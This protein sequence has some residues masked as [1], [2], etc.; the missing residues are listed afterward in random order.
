MTQVRPPSRRRLLESAGAVPLLFPF[1]RR[2]RAAEAP[3]REPRL[4]LFMQTNGTST[5]QFFPDATFK[6]SAILDPL[7]S[8]QA[9]RTR[10]TVIHGLHNR[11]GGAGNGHDV[12]FPGLFSGYRSIGSFNEPWGGGPSLDQQLK[13]QLPLT[14]VFPTLNCGVLATSAPV[15]KQH[16]AS[17]SY[18]AARQPVPT[19][20]NVYKLYAMFFPTSTSGGSS[21]DSVMAAKRRLLQKRTV[22]DFVAGD[23][24]GLRARVGALDRAKLDVHEGALRE[25][26]K[27]LGATVAEGAPAQCRSARV[28]AS[29]LDLAV[30]DNIPQLARLMSDFVALAL[31]CGQTRMVTYAMGNGGERWWYRWLGLNENAHEDIAHRDFGDNQAI[32][33]KV[34]KIGR[35]HAEQVA[36]LARALDAFPEG[37]GSVLD[38][39]LLVWGNE[40]ATGTHA[41]ENIP[42]VTIGG[43][44]GRL[45]TI[46]RLVADGAQPY[47]RLG[48]TLLNLMG[49]RTAG[50]GEEP[51]CGNLSGVDIA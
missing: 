1:L 37:D 35:W 19:E 30:E 13:R 8:D 2:A 28:P 5:K 25:F 16:R 51:A 43:A 22:L 24:R 20:A 47:H 3:A 31:A 26:E 23:L 12:G 45:K 48:A 33:A 7:L 36:Y 9:L 29:G 14:E 44:A 17:F 50:F 10:T 18:V 34:V 49:V 32:T 27:R 46:G 4:V 11:Q 40:V 21:G 41:M 39:S 15:W 42:I 6:S 38:G